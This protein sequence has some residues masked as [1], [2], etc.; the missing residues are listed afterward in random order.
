MGPSP[1]PIYFFLMKVFS[2]KPVPHMQ[3][4]KGR[5]LP[6]LGR[7]VEGGEPVCPL[8]HFHI[9]NQ[10]RVMHAKENGQ[11]LPALYSGRF[12]TQ[13]KLIVVELSLACQ[14]I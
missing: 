12:D 1:P 14:K 4:S 13:D 10:I 7:R 8:C 3:K 11:H 5:H 2:M 6:V 9:F